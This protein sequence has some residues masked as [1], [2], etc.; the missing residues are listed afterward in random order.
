MF[1]HLCASCL[2]GKLCEVSSPFILMY[3][4]ECFF[5]NKAGIPSILS[6]LKNDP[7]SSNLAI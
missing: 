1:A 7:F 3:E 2:Y 5:I 4:Q 6:G